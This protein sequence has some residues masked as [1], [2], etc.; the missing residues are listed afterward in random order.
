MSMALPAPGPRAEATV[1][2]CSRGLVALT[3][4][5][6]P[7]RDVT[8]H[9]LDVLE[10]RRVPA[11]FFVVGQR[12]DDA[13]WLTLDAYD[14]GFQIANHSYAHERLTTLSD[15]A[16]EHSL[17]HTRRSIVRSGAHPSNLV[18]APYGLIN[19]RVRRV[20]TEMGLKHVAWN[21]D[22]A[23]WEDYSGTTI[24][25]RVLARLH[26]DRRNTVLLH[27]GITNSP[28]T[29]RA[30]PT[31]IRK[32]RERGYCF[33]ALGSQGKPAPP[34]PRARVSDVTVSES[35]TGDH[36]WM[37]FEIRLD[38][39][40]SRETSVR[41]ETVARSA[42]SGADYALR[43]LRVS[44]PV[45]VTR[46][47]VYV[48]AK[49]DVLDEPDEQ[50]RVQLSAPRHMRLADA[51]G[52]GRIL[53]DDKPPR[54]RIHSTQTIEPD[55]VSVDV[56]VTLSLSQPS[57]RWIAV[58]ARTVPGTADQLD[59]EQGQWRVHFAPGETRTTIRISVLSDLLDEPVE[60]LEIVAYE[61][62]HVT[63]LDP[64]GDIE[65]MP[66]G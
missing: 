45:G 13:P 28:N 65:I 66:P 7:S 44:F 43:D 2:P 40:T 29:L 5:D 55:S 48:K 63:V 21:V 42:T 53:D 15:G 36:S 46:R 6:G 49:G 3:F 38:R 20:M 24:A 22:P 54:L 14:R 62:N 8:A 23:D 59:F 52:I 4:D 11:T 57:G 27:D 16:V 39:P 10:D 30:V 35:D 33:A 18:R 58:S 60:R 19:A 50:F 47:S 31:I 26:P 61:W 41:V 12:V 34:T 56:P 9:L 64:S 1:Q 17:R 32:A 25:A 37:R 51:T